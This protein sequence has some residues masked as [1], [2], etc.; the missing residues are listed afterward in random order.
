MVRIA[1]TCNENHHL[2]NPL[3]N[4]YPCPE[5][6][7]RMDRIFLY[8]NNNGYIGADACC[9]YFSSGQAT[10][11]D[12]L[13]V[14]TRE[15]ID[16]VKACE[17]GS[18]KSLGRDSYLCQGTFDVLLQALGA[19]CH[20][21]DMVASGT[22]DH[23]F[24]L[25]RPPGHHAGMNSAGGFCIFNNSGILARYLKEKHG[26][27]KIAILNIDAHASDGTHSIFYADPDV[28]CISIH[29]DPMNLYPHTG[30]MKDIGV[31]PALG[32]SINMEMP[33]NSGN[34]EY[35]ILFEE[36]IGKILKDFEPQILILECGFDAYYKESLTQLELTVDGYYNIANFLSQWNVICLLE[37]GYHEDIGMLTAVV[38]EGLKG[39][40][41]IKDTVSQI[42]LLASRNVNTRKEFQEKMIKLKLL[43]GPYWDLGNRHQVPG[44]GQIK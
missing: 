44:G 20:A 1:L 28:L 18:C 7:S 11:D 2:H 38:L 9:E 41:T 40:R 32:L 35:A 21:G 13:R 36:V 5:D 34:K 39:R 33:K 10:I 42:D 26:I 15:Y 3:L 14:H 23:A 12:L 8:L 6:P 4:G 27:G 19:V 24:A 31:R 29:Q 16:R 17:D 22:C 43:L 30:F 25:V 37:G